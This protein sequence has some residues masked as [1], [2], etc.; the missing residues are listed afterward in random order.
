METIGYGDHGVVCRWQIGEIVGV[1]TVE[2]VYKDNLLS[3]GC[4]SLLMPVCR[5]VGGGGTAM[6]A[7]WGTMGTFC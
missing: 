1:G 3:M 7:Q 6:R 5:S 2:L 4:D